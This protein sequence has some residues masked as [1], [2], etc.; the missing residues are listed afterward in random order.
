MMFAID[1]GLRREEQFGLTWDKV[2]LK[3]GEIL[4][5]GSTKSGKPRRVPLLPRTARIL[6]QLPRHIRSKYVFC[7]HNGDRFVHMNKGMKA[8]RRRAG[9]K[10]LRWH[11]LRRTCGCRLLQDHAMSMEGVKEWLGHSTVVVTERMSVKE[12]LGHSTVVVT[13]RTYAFLEIEHL[14]RA[15]ANAAQ[16]SAQ[17]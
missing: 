1:T 3:A 10:A 4:L 15:V 14:H 8:A 16:K 12:W 2:D 13:E 7:H 5:D 17:G 9:L 11:D 6:A